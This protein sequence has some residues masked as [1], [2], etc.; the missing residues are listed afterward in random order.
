MKVDTGI[1]IRTIVS[2]IAEHFS[3]EELPGRKV[4][5]IVNLAPRTIKGI[6]SRGMILLSEDETGH[7]TFMMSEDAIKNG[8]SCKVGLPQYFF[9]ES[10]RFTNPLAWIGAFHFP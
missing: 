7:M 9:E 5:V 6:E 2:G 1:D 3:A 4:S 8:W 10:L